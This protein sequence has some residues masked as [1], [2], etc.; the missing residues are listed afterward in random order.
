MLPFENN[1]KVVD[2]DLINN[3]QRASDSE[4]FRLIINDLGAGWRLGARTSTG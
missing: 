3:I 4:R 1:G 2:L